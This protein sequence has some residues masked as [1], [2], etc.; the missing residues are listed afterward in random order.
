ME[1]PLP[2]GRG[3]FNVDPGRFA[4]DTTTMHVTYY[5]ANKPNGEVSVFEQLTLHRKRSDARH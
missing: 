5:N 4:G 3:A 2:S 1:N